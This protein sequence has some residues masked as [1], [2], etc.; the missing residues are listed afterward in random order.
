MSV[1]FWFVLN[2]LALLLLLIVDFG[3]MAA[4]KK[5]EWWPDL[6]SVL[7]NLLTGGIISFLFYF[8]V[9]VVPERRRR[10]VIK[11][12]LAKMYRRVKLD[13]LWQ[14]VFAS[15]KGG[16]HDLSTSLDEV[17]RLL[18]VNAFKAAF[19][20]GRESNDGFYAFENQMDDKTSEFLEIILNLEILAKQIEYVLSH[21]AI[22]NQ[23]IF[24]FFKRLEAFLIKMRHLQPGYDESKALCRF[25][26]EIFAGFDFVDGYRGYDVV[27][28]MIHDI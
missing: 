23:N 4:L 2:S 20:H 18:D 12:N 22:D 1:R 9:V 19:E 16:R 21:Y 28:K 8:L 27:E 24:D 3:F 10:S 11:T 26:W 25:I 5:S 13:I 15:I 14:I 6:F 17:E 7:T